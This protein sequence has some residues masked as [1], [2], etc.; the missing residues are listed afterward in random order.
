MS[1]RLL[2][3]LLLLLSFPAI[4]YSS[5]GQLRIL[6]TGDTK[7]IRASEYAS[8]N[9]GWLYLADALSPEPGE[10]PTLRLDAGDLLG[11][12][13]FSHFLTHEHFPSRFPQLEIL[14][15]LQWDTVVLGNADLALSANM[16]RV[17]QKTA[18]FPM[19]T[20][21]VESTRNTWPKF[22]SFEIIEKGGLRIEVYGLTT[23][24][25]PIWH[26]K[27][28]NDL[29][30]LGI[31]QSAKEI[32]QILREDSGLISLLRCCTAAQIKSSVRKKT[33]MLASPTPTLGAGWSIMYLELI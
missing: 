28:G 9:Q 5:K 25:A 17:A 2:I 8:R 19:L 11:G 22:P 10:V 26:E 6:I 29:A 7:G 23:P 12:S 20:G 14:N 4:G 18:N 21:N 1:S 33:C 13:D 24:A 27:L 3:F 30:F 31:L 32:T 15:A 16:L